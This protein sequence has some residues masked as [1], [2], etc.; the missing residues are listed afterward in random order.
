MRAVDLAALR[1]RIRPVRAAHAG[2]FVPREPEP[3]QVRLQRRGVFF[4]PAHGVG[5]LD[6]Q[7]KHAAK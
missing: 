2:T 5:V 1:L 3:A 7:Q 6:A 4:V